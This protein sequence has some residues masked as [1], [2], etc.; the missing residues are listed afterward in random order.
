MDNMEEG[1][2]RSLP[3]TNSFIL[4]GFLLLCQFW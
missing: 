3:P 4:L 2:V 1:V